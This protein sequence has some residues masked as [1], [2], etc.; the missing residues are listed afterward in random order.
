LLLQLQKKEEM[1]AVIMEGEVEMSQ[2]QIPF[3]FPF[4]FPFPIP[5]PDYFQALDQN[6]P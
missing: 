3:P 1:L 2:S 6:R 4:P 5:I